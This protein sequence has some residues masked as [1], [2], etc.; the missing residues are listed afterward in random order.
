MTA[1]RTMLLVGGT[2]Q[3]LARAK[4]LGVRVVL[5]QQPHRVDAFQ[6]EH[7]DA[8][9][10]VDYTNWDTVWPLA[11]AARS[12]WRFD[13][14]VSLTEG[15][16]DVAARLNQRFG[17]RGTRPEVSRRL[18]D[19]ALMRRHLT[20]KGKGTLPWARVTGPESLGDFG[21]RSGYPF[22]VKPTDSTAGF[23]VIRVNGPEDLPGAWRR[24]EE[25]RERPHRR[26]AVYFTV[27]EFLMEA[28]VEGP[29]FSVEAFSF[30]GR[31]AVV[32]VTE[33]LLHEAG[34]VELGHALPARLDPAAHGEIT[35]AVTEFL[36][37]MGVTDGAS[38]TELRLGPQGPVV[39]ESHNR[40]GG[41]H[42]N[43]LVEAAYGI[44]MVGYGLGWPMGM[45][46]ELTEPP[47]ARAAACTRFVF[48]DPGTVMAVSGVGSVAARSDV[49]AAEVGVW[50]GE[51]VGPLRDNRDRL[52]FVAATAADT[53]AAIALCEELTREIRIDVVPHAY[54]GSLALKAA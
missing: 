44:D 11:K 12:I 51:V 49:L 28:Y 18:R 17:F 24:I 13:A 32:A 15:G 16:L 53:A 8:L 25:M 36:E 47:V 5:L 1:E 23:G 48:R 4:E 52:G 38:H 19:K 41:G 26:G 7:A 54:A 34:F 40:I 33:K 3:H 21:S 30:G 42:I 6:T 14:V 45:V 10:M 27:R 35:R 50:P 46:E 20:A 9:L 31:H 39:I 43:E 2:D 29:E 22:I 37:V